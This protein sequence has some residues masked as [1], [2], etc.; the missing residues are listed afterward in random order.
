ME[1]EVERIEMIKVG[2]NRDL[3]QFQKYSSKNTKSVVTNQFLLHFGLDVSGEG[4]KGV[5]D[6]Y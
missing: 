3:T 2:V 5:F 4:E 6:V 1:L